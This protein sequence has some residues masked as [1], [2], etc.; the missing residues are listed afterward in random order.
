M[1]AQSKTTVYLVR[2]AATANN[3]AKPPQ[4]Q[5]RGVDPDLAP[6]GIRQAEVTRDHLALYGIQACYSS[7]MLRAMRTAEILAEPHRL[8]P[9][10][11]ADLAECDVG[12]WEGLSWEEIERR[13][14]E[15]YRRYMA[16]PGKNGY[17]NGETFTDVYERTAAAMEQILAAHDG[18]SILVVTHH[19]VGRVYLASLLGLPSSKARL[20][21]LD[22]CGVSVIVKKGGAKPA[23]K[24]LNSVFHLQGVG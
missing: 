24:T 2:H 20:V 19:I 11:V 3:L 17:V 8:E 9:R 22:N 18:E 7:P 4:L 21:S 13:Y 23:V 1:T 10:A 16:N 15:E 5:G 14:P 12:D 6:L